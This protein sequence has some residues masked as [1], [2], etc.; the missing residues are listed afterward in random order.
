[1]NKQ[2]AVNKKGFTLMELLVV[3][4]I[5]GVLAAIAVPSYLR[6]VEKGKATEAIQ[7]LSDIAKGEQDYFYARSRYTD[8]FGDMSI[9]V[10]GDATGDTHEGTYFTYTLE[11]ETAIAERNGSDDP[12]I[13]YRNYEDPITYC[14]PEGN[15]YC[16]ML[17]LLPGDRNTSVGNWQSCSAEEG[18]Y[19]CTKA[20]TRNTTI[21]YTC[22]GTYN[23][24]GTYTEK[25]CST[26]SGGQQFCAS[27]NYNSEGNRTK[28][29]TC[30][31]SVTDKCVSKREKTYD[32]N[33]NILS[34][35]TCTN[36][37]ADGSCSSYSNEGLDKIY[38]TNG[39][40]IKSLTCKTVDSSGNCTAYRL[41]YTYSYDVNGN[42][43]T[44][45]HCSAVDSS[46]NC[47][48]YSAYGGNVNYTYDTNGNVITKR[49]CSAVDSSGNC[50][51]YAIN[52]Y[53]YTYDANGNKLTERICSSVD[54]SGNCTAYGSWGNYDYT[55]DANGNQL[56]QR[57][58]S[59][60]D[61]SSGNCTAYSTT[62]NFA[63]DANGNKLTV[64]ECSSVDSSG[65][66]TSYNAYGDSI[67]YTYDANGNM[68]TESACSYVNS[69]GNCTEYFGSDTYT[70]DANGNIASRVSSYC[71]YM[72]GNVCMNSQERTFDYGYDENGNNIYYKTSTSYSYIYYWDDLNGNGEMDEGEYDGDNGSYENILY[73]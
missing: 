73:Y 4:I 51:A 33:G 69:S 52:S 67:N 28:Q 17:G 35:R 72:E 71:D 12:Y 26:T 27:A 15:K 50:T 3:V 8:D 62:Y 9:S 10:F 64:R 34:E 7:A 11:D 21:G 18:G 55:Y 5:I 14:Q 36:N 60:V 44:E 70:Y 1:M 31:V 39:N 22:A 49:P 6:A 54:S 20:C 41:G 43:L 48:E 65:N 38:D 24:D 25:V 42:K 32:E 45:R 46:G 59:S 53:L 68:L 58:C 40:L 30:D 66:C 16:T 61:S 29:V 19:P 47:T 2:K 57:N 23:Q 13:L 56:T 63:Y 37:N